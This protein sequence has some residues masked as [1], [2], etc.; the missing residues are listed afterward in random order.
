MG[1]TLQMSVRRS[2]FGIL[3]YIATERSAKLASQIFSTPQSR[4]FTDDE[5]ALLAT[6]QPLTLENNLAA[7]VWNCDETNKGETI[8]LVHGWQRHR[9]SLGKFVQPLV[10]A[11]KRVVAFDAPAHGDSAGKQTNPLEYAKAILAVGKELGHFDG[12]IAHSMGGGATLIALSQ[13]LEAKKIV[14]LASA[15]D[16]EYQMRFFA[17]YL[18]MPHKAATRLVR[19]LE[20][21][22]QEDVQKLNSA[23]VCKDLRQTAL[24]FHDPEDKRVPYQ[25]SVAISQQMQQAKLVTVNGLGHAGVLEDETIIKQSVK[26]LSEDN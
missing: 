3:G 4:P 13:G 17:K 5:R 14:L 16:W 23:Y 6:G 19:L 2:A 25:D 10:K 22:A 9:A 20:S 11:G 8:L 18:G 24:L 26:F 12:I 21:Q 15:A 1:S 7:T